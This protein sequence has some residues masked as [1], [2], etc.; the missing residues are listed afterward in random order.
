MRFRLLASGVFVK[1]TIPQGRGMPTRG[2]RRALVGFRGSHKNR[3]AS[4][5]RIYGFD[6]AVSTGGAPTCRS[7]H[8]RRCSPLSRRDQRPLWLTLQSLWALVCWLLHSRPRGCPRSLHPGPP[9]WRKATVSIRKPLGS[10]RLPT[11][12]GPRPVHF[13][14]WRRAGAIEAHALRHHPFSRRRREPSRFTLHE[15]EPPGRFER[16]TARFEAGCSS[17]LS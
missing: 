10:N 5:I 14:C 6:S 1:Y 3:L 7:P 15:L 8:P 16:P 4:L 11:G 9:K 13:P 12:A 2:Q 17:P